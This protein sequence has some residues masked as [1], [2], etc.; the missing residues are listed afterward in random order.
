MSLYIQEEERLYLEQLK[1]SQTKHE[2]FLSLSTVIKES[3][4]SGLILSMSFPFCELYRRKIL[5]NELHELP[6]Q[7]LIFNLL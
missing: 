4:D 6:L 3:L 1:S 2:V 7:S 5:N